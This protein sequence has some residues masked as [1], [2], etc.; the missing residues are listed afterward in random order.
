MFAACCRDITCDIITL[1]LSK[2]LPFKFRVKNINT[3]I[4]RGLY[5]EIKY[6]PALTDRFAKRNV[7]ASAQDLVTA[8]RAK[9]III[10]S[11]CTNPMY[12]RGPY[13][14]INLGTLF[15]LAPDRA[16]STVSKSCRIVLL[17]SETR[18][19]VKGVFEIENASSDD[20][21]AIDD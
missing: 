6:S 18:K 10:S 19:S 12:L 9:N 17:H 3:A 7:I 2:K 20:A 11:G 16:L 5:F 14:V 4:N 21:M 8:S 13:D 1:D 15:G